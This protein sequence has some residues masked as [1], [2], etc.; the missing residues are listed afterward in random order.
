MTVEV[1]VQQVLDL[2]LP[3]GAY[4]M[5]VDGAGT[6][7][8]LPDAGMDDW[9]LETRSDHPY[10]E[11]VRQD[12]FRP[13]S[14]NLFR[15]AG[16]APLGETESGVSTLALETGPSLVAWRTIPTTDWKLVVV[17]AEDHLL[18]HVRQ[19]G[20][21]FNRVGI[22]MLLLLLGFYA[23]FFTWVYRTAQQQSSAL[24]EP[25]QALGAMARRIAG[26]AFVPG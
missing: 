8:A 26:G 24:T 9:G 11:V 2:E 10:T 13:E 17:V 22:G 19:V 7:M 16:D 15:L 5:L 14:Y 21:N 6:L 20:S 12:T 3:W 1:F 4:G 25:L 18:A 23:V